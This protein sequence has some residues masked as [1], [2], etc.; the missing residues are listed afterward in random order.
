[1]IETQDGYNTRTSAIQEVT[2]SM[3]LLYYLCLDGQAGVLGTSFA[4]ECST[5]MEGGGKQV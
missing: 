3:L 2:M 1:M 4:L 5:R